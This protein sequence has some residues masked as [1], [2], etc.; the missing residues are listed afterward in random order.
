[1][2][3]ALTYFSAGISKMIH[4]GPRWLNGY[5][6]QTHTFGDAL[7][8]GHPVGVWLA[9]STARDRA[10]GLHHRARAVL[11]GLPVPAAPG[12]AVHPGRAL[13]FQVGLYVTAGYDFFQHMVLLGLLLLFLYP[14]WWRSIGD[15]RRPVGK[16]RRQTVDSATAKPEARR[17]RISTEKTKKLLLF[18]VPSPCPPC[19]CFAVMDADILR[20]QW[21]A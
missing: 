8:R 7:A 4:S 5:T 18:S 13:G 6:L 3:I 2:L 11:L 14:A 17:T 16:R 12:A 9:H 20:T 21:H 19:P 1:M 10:V 15:W